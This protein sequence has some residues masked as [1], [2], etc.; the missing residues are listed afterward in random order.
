MK[1]TSGVYVAF[2]SLFG[3]V[4]FGQGIENKKSPLLKLESVSLFPNVQTFYSANQSL[5]DFNELAPGSVILARDYSDFNNFD[6]TT[7]NSSSGIEGMASFLL[8]SKK[9]GGYKSSTIF[10]VGLGFS[11][12]SNFSTSSQKTEQFTFDTLASAQTGNRLLLDSLNYDAL[13]AQ[14]NSNLMRLSLSI[15]FRSRQETRLSIYGGVGLYGS[16]AFNSYTDVS[17]FRSQQSIVTDVDGNQ[18]LGNT[19]EEFSSTQR[20][21][22]Y[23]NQNTFSCAVYAPIGITMRLSKHHSFWKR[24][25]IFTEVRP[26]VDV[27]SIPEIGTHTTGFTEFGFGAK[28]II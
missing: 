14:H 17:L 7:S 15:I 28:A 24:M 27:T 5:E 21:E 19:N 13:S 10:R 20:S 25:S 22:R 11:N 16:M 8:R 6:F 9:D 26:G 1:M 12:G 2:L 3:F 23:A 4:L 18:F